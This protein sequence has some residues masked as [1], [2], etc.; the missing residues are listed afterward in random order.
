MPRLICILAWAIVALSVG[1]CKEL[2]SECASDRMEREAGKRHSVEEFLRLHD[3]SVACNAG[4]DLYFIKPIAGF[5]QAGIIAALDHIEKKGQKVTSA[6]NMRLILGV[7]VEMKTS[8]SYDFCQDKATLTRIRG[9]ATASFDP[10]SGD[11][12][13]LLDAIGN[14]CKANPH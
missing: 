2:K 4:V 9:A 1:S 3:T 7:A 12:N 11:R 6:S 5:G 8:S 13:S 14:I 10:A